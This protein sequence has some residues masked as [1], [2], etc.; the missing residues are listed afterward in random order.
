MAGNILVNDMC[1]IREAMRVYYSR[2]FKGTAEKTEA[3]NALDSFLKKQMSFEET[4]DGTVIYR[5]GDTRSLEN[6]PLFE[7]WRNKAFDQVDVMFH[8]Y[9]FD[10]L[11]LENEKTEEQIF[12]EINEYGS[13]F[14]DPFVITRER[15][16]QKLS[17][18]AGEGLIRVR[19]EDGQKLYLNV[20]AP[21]LLTSDLLLFF[22]EILPCGIAGY[23]YERR[24]HP[25]PR[26]FRFKHHF[27]AM[28]LESDILCQLFDAMGNKTEVSL[29][30]FEGENITAVP[31]KILCTTQAGKYYL[32]YYDRAKG[33][34]LSIRT[35]DIREVRHGKAAYDYDPLFRDYCKKLEHAWGN[36]AGDK[37]E[38]VAFELKFEPAEDYVLIRLSREKRF[39]KI[40]KISDEHVRFEADVTSTWEI[41]PWI[42]TFM[43][44]IV[45]LELS[46]EDAKKQFMKD[47]EGMSK[48]Y[49]GCGESI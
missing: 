40:I 12:N 37:T 42:E 33:S 5:S 30:L 38:H 45:K 21:G 8:F 3:Q 24:R 49:G 23:T 2:G 25:T 31:M 32:G 27:T 26:T 9:V 41:L 39:G 10:I 13:S 36:L 43:G 14:E 11:D 19:E 28:T 4:S 46:N 34:Y 47:L 29:V 1:A 17:E 48:I 16:A 15:L 20:P 22:S 7:I 18:Y 6:N 35:T 44:W